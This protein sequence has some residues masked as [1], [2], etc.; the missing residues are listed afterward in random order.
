[1]EHLDEKIELAKTTTGFGD[2]S[3]RPLGDNGM[4]VTR[5]A[6]RWATVNTFNFIK[7]NMPKLAY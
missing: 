2:E 1:M 6:D 3:G 4:T 7:V 5:A